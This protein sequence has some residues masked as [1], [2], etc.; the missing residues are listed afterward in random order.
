MLIDPATG[1]PVRARDILA[2]LADRLAG[3][4]ERL[5]CARRL[6]QVREMSRGP[7]GADRQLAV[8]E[9]T[10]DLRA[11]ARLQAGDLS[12][13][14]IDGADGPPVEAIGRVGTTA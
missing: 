14:G 13:E 6:E 10:G 4:A 12:T 1:R 11:V 7:G 2:G 3:E 8:F 9:R 5:G